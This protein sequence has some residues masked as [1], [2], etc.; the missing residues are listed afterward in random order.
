MLKVH[1]F[2]SSDDLDIHLSQILYELIDHSIKVKGYSSIALSG[3]NTPI[4]IYRKLSSNSISWDKVFISIVDERFT[5][6]DEF[7]NFKNISDCFL[8]DNKPAPV[9][10]P[11]SFSQHDGIVSLMRKKID[12]KRWYCC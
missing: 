7:S 3:G 5:N 4:G 10:F 2:D 1:N 11:H 9:F 8:S 6:K 12:L